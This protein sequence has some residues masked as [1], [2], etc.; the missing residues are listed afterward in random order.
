MQSNDPFE[1]DGNGGGGTRQ[2]RRAA[3]PEA[4]E[5]FNP[6]Q[7]NQQA[8]APGED[9]VLQQMTFGRVT[10]NLKWGNLLIVA[11]APLLTLAERLR[12][13]PDQF[14]SMRDIRSAAQRGLYGFRNQISRG[15]VDDATSK[16]G[17]LVLGALID[18]IALN[19]PWPGK[20]EWRQQPLAALSGDGRSQGQ[21]V[22]E[23]MEE[24]L[25]S[26]AHDYDILEL[27]YLVLALG[28]EGPFRTDARGPLLLIQYRERLLAAI[29]AEGGNHPR[30]SVSWAAQGK[31][32]K[33]LAYLNPFTM[34][35]GGVLFIAVS[36]A[37]A[38]WIFGDS[39]PPLVADSTTSARPS[40]L[41]SPDLQP[42]PDLV[43]GKV[44]G[45][46]QGD[47]ATKV[48]SFD[49]TGPS[50]IIG[51]S[52]DLIFQ[53]GTAAPDQ[54]NSGVVRRI[55]AATGVAPGPVYL[56]AQ[57]NP[58]GPDLAGQ[59][60]AALGHQ[61]EP[62]VKERGQYLMTFIIDPVAGPSGAPDDGIQI[63]LGK[64]VRPSSLADG[65]YLWP[66]WY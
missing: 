14:P 20:S 31:T 9:P 54:A 42:Q 35:V 13:S 1:L 48:V 19:G 22:F 61:L 46:L 26:P 33:A 23:L 5:P 39:G 16:A 24:A 30:A 17:E 11:G 53:P 66:R 10:V 36:L 55:G 58:A 64:G 21:Q 44:R 4:V 63:V 41:L 60:L 7:L 49:D 65:A 51:V 50:L 62:W 8:D 6:F 18:D 43:P 28:F 25:A 56:I 3:R 12:N 29:R 2:P 15:D 40:V 59:R 27:I 52:G 47:I 45:V 57:R 32:H 34:A 37:V 38:V